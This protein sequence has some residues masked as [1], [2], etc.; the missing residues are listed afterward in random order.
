[1]KTAVI[2]Q[3]TYLPWL[4]Y[5]DL[6]DQADVF[7]FL[8]S[9]Q[10]DKRSWQQRNRIKSPQGELLLTVP[11]LS[12]GRYDQKIC[13]VELDLTQNFQETHLKAIKYNY[14]KAVNFK[15]YIDSFEEVFL[16]ERRLLADLN[17]DLI[18]WL[19]DILGIKAEVLRSSS[20]SVNGKKAELLVDICKAV[21]AG[22][23]LSPLG[24]KD[25]IDGTDVFPKNGI[26]LAYHNFI[27]PV[28]R[29][30]YGAFFSHL[31]VI[32]LL[33]NEGAQSLSIVQSGRGSGR[34]V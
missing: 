19:K 25:Y 33:F 21:G 4:G 18:M 32:D 30:L 15:K 2:M 13:D 28:Y 17:I 29:Q 26:D 8:D 16:R 31:T 1:M 27:H 24:A 5:F 20:L 22:R 6:I 11:V 34:G 9:V 10:F 14:S 23:Y 12:K 3:P 7:V